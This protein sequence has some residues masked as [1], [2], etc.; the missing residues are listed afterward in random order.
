MTVIVKIGRRVP[1]NWFKRTAVKARGLMTFQ[2]N[3]WLIIDRSLTMA[4]RKATASTSN[5]NF[6][7]QT[8]REPESM[9]YDLEW[10]EVN[11][12]GNPDEEQE[13][14]D[15][16][17]GMYKSLGKLFKNELP[18]DNELTKP[19]KT[20]RITE[21][22][23]NKAYKAGYTNTENK[24]IAQKLLDLGIITVVEKV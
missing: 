16:A 11:I 7:K 10:I 22:Q 23:L 3:I 15:E 24:S 13:E 17:M 9:N 14:Y 2:E 18:K 5:I 20:T 8:Y 21:N 1:R 19:F 12:V 6:T 4:K